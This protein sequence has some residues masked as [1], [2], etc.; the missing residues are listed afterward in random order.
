MSNAERDMSELDLVLSLPEFEV[1]QL[2]TPLTDAEVDAILAEG[3]A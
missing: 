1:E 2:V 3:E